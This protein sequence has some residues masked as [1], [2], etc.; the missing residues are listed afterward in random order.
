MGGHKNQNGS[1]RWFLQH[2]EEGI[3]CSWIHCLGI[4]NNHHSPFGLVGFQGKGLTEGANL[5]NF[6]E[7]TGR[8]HPDDVRVVTYLDFSAGFANTAGNVGFLPD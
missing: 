3:A 1:E 6:D 7:R 8:F 5:I 2:F 4:G